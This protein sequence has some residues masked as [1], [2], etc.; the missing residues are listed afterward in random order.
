MLKLLRIAALSSLSSV[1]TAW[2]DEGHFIS[3][4]H[5]SGFLIRWIVAGI[6]EIVLKQEGYLKEGI[7]F[8][9][10]QSILF[11][12]G[13]ESKDRKTRYITIDSADSTS[14]ITHPFK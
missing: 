11:N 12:I 14:G 4:C 13:S 10:I 1:V 5:S 6:A 9:L 7:D 8:D 2:W 3:K